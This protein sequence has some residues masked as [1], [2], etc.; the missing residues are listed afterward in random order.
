MFERIRELL[1]GERNGKAAASGPTKQERAAA[2]AFKA[3][4][5]RHNVAPRLE[6]TIDSEGATAWRI[7]FRELE[8]KG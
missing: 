5:E 6:V 4:C 2:E 3:L 1:G 8:G 7:Y